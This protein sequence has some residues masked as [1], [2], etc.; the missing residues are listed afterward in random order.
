MPLWLSCRFAR[1]LSYSSAGMQT[2]LHLISR[3]SSIE[4]S[5]LVPKRCWAILGS[6]CGQLGHPLRVRRLSV[7]W[8]GLYLIAPLIMLKLS[9]EKYM[10]WICWC[11]LMGKFSIWEGHLLIW[12]ARTMSLPSLYCIVKPYF[13]RQSSTHGRWGGVVCMGLCCFISKGL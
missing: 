5:F 3:P 2:L 11:N 1:V 12:S 10:C 7:L 6:W 13:C 4:S 8:V 9:F